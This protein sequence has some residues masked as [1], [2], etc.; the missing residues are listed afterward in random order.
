MTKDIERVARAICVASGQNPD[1]LTTQ[2]GMSVANWMSFEGQAL[3]AI[4][5][6][7]KPSNAMLNAACAA[8][9]PGKR[10]TQKRVSCKAKHGIRYRAMIDAAISEG[11]KGGV[12]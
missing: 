10:P 8:M 11:A 4:R 3:A 5:A 12:E 7:R 9:S 1:A 2:S 6:I